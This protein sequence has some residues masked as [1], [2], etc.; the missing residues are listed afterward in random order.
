MPKIDP[1]PTEQHMTDSEIIDL[2]GGTSVVAEMLGIK[3]PSVSEWRST[4]IP[5]TRKHTL[6]LMFPKLVPSEWRPKKS[7]KAA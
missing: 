6:S 4:G 1:K 3:P 2:L 5:E 7:K